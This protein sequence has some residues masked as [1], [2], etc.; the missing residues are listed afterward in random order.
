MIFLGGLAQIVS[1][2]ILVK[3][4][5]AVREFFLKKNDEDSMNTRMMALHAS[6]FGLFLI[7]D[8]IN[9]GSF[10]IFVLFPNTVAWPIYQVCATIM[11]FG[12]FVAQLLLAKIFWNFGEKESTDSETS[13]LPTVRTAE[14]D[15]E[16]ELQ[17]RI[18][19]GFHREIHGILSSIE[20]GALRQ[21]SS[22][23]VRLPT[24]SS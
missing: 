5:F 1:G 9:F 21:S 15:D 23:S 17:A 4:V 20:S 3:S 7:V 14:Y 19:N 16:A 11:I 6:A 22:P 10:L 18:W 24:G 13:R 2:I 8:V 12:S